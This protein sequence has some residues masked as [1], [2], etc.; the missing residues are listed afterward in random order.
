MKNDLSG[1]WVATSDVIKVLVF[2]ADGTC[3]VDGTPARWQAAGDEVWLLDG[4]TRAGTKWKF[5]IDADGG[6]IFSSPEDFKY[7]GGSKYIYYQ[8]IDPGTTIA[9]H[10]ADSTT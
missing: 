6:L 10:R 9:F 5:A 4:K 7:L 3:Q 8:M 2:R 1:T